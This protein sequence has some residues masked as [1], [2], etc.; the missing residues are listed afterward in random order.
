MSDQAGAL[1]QPQSPD[2]TPLSAAFLMIAAGRTARERAEAELEELDLALR[3]VS[4]LGHLAREPGLSYSE[5]ARRA[6]IT[7]QSIQAT[8]G[9]LEQRGAIERRTPPGRGRRAVLAVTDHGHQLLAEALATFAAADRRLIETLGEDA[10]VAL[11][12]LLW[13]VVRDPSTP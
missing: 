3:H 2:G 9:Q 12:D 10:H 13:R 5:L 1:R 7:A 6:G 4:A 8:L 11:T